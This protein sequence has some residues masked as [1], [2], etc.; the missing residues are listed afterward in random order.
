MLPP[1]F[2]SLHFSREPEFWEGD[3]GIT[4]KGVPVPWGGA[5]KHIFYTGEAWSYTFPG[6]FRWFGDQTDGSWGAEF[7]YTGRPGGSFV[8]VRRMKPGHDTWGVKLMKKTAAVDLSFEGVAR[9]TPVEFQSTKYGIDIEHNQP[10]FEEIYE[11]TALMRFLSEH[12]FK[13][14]LFML[15]GYHYPK[16]INLFEALATGEDIQKPAAQLTDYIHIT[17]LPDGL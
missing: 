13:S 16:E 6:I 2:N 10:A 12:N 17:M 14:G 5:A 1:I 15:R 11:K 7:P 9:N 3:T 4:V 8:V